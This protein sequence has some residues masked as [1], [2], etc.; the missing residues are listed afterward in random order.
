MNCRRKSTVGWS[1]GVL[2]DIVAVIF[3]MLPMSILAYN[4]SMYLFSVRAFSCL[5]EL[6]VRCIQIDLLMI[7]GILDYQFA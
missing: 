4:S 5:I 6:I 3:S 7:L 1:I 2:L